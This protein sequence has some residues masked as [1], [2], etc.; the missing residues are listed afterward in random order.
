MIITLNSR[1]TLIP[2]CQLIEVKVKEIWDF[3]QLPLTLVFTR[4][5]PWYS[6]HTSNSIHKTKGFTVS[7]LR[8]VLFPRHRKMPISRE[9]GTV[10]EERASRQRY[11]SLGFLNWAVK[12]K[13]PS[14]GVLLFLSEQT[15]HGH[16]QKNRHTQQQTDR[17]DWNCYQ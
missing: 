13:F 14:Q 15:A 17:P 9:W 6:H 3:T 2:Q 11:G 1:M 10:S 12:I 7:R 16:N 5:W 8:L 4:S